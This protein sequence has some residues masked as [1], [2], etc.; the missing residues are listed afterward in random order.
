MSDLSKYQ[1]YV[2]ENWDR[3]EIKNA[4]YNPRIISDEAYK[5]L[6]SIIKDS[7]FGL[8]APLTVN[9]RTGYLVGGHQRLSVLDDL[10][11]GK[12][13]S[14][15]VS[16]VD[17]DERDERQ[18]NIFLNNTSAQGKWD[19]DLL[20]EI[21]LEYNFDMI[22]ELGFEKYDIDFMFPEMGGLS[23]TPEQVNVE[24]F[25]DETEAERKEEVEAR[26]QAT[27]E[28]RKEINEKNK[29]KDED[30]SGWYDIKDDYHLTLVFPTT[31]E[32]QEFMKKYGMKNDIKFVKT[33][34]FFRNINLQDQ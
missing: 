17:F 5:K 8:L 10:H 33:D 12:P 19:T 18:A 13:Y 6:K 14:I 11:K 15:T 21:Q 20:S 27:K 3:T 4:P 29:Q 22:G 2:I 23:M 9:R 25:I 32:K 7:K 34:D 16:V 31:K 28:L 30:G 1:N 26:K 24:N